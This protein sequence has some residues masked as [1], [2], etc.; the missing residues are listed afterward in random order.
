MVAYRD[1]REYQ[2]GHP[3]NIA[4]TGAVRMM[5]EGKFLFDILDLQSDMTPYKVIILPDVVTVSP[6]LK[7][8]LDTYVAGGGKIL[9]SGDSCVGE[10]GQRH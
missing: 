6:E 10:A 9:A 5:L 3:D 1:A 4:T 7:E 8:K 2:N